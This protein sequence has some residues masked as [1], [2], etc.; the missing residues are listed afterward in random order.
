MGDN[1]EGFKRAE[2]YR[3]AILDMSKIPKKKALEM[4]KYE[5]WIGWYHLGQGSHPPVKAQKVGEV[6]ASSF[7]IACVIYEHQSS[8]D[9][10]KRQMEEGDTYIEDCHFGSWYY[11]VRTN[12]NSWTGRYFETREEAQETIDKM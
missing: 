12:S 11:D 3:F 4:K 2:T 9:G 1:G 5:I 7:K 8:I 6:E 10:L